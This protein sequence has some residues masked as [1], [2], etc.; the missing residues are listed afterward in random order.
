MSMDISILFTQDPIVVPPCVLPS[1]EVG[2]CVEFQGIVR[3]ME[4][5][6]ALPGLHYEAYQPMAVRLLGRIFDELA[7]AYP[8]AEVHFIHR[9]GWVPVGESSLFLRVLAR[10]RGESLRFCAEAIDRMKAE[11][12]IW[13]LNVGEHSVIDR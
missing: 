3:E 6:R 11:V 10:H 13:K 4:R 2:A 5:D 1:R 9:L 7:A 12:P 8:C